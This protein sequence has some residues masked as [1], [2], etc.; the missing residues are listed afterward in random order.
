MASGTERL[1]LTAR[2]SSLPRFAEAGVEA[3]ER[4]WLRALDVNAAD[5][6]EAL[7]EEIEREWGG[8]DVLINNAGVMVRSV[9]EHV[10]EAD[11]LAQMGVNF[12][13]PMELA[14]LCLPSM[15]A[16][17]RGRI[18]NVSSVGGMMAMPTM[19]IYSASKFALEGGCEALWYE[20]RPWNIKVSL[21]EPGFIR[22]DA[23]QKVRL[24]ELSAHSVED[25]HD[26]YHAHYEHMSPFI[27]RVMRY[28]FATHER[29]ARKIERTM[30][31]RSPPLRVSGT[32]DAW[33]FSMMRRVL[34][35]RLY[36]WLLYRS[37]PKVR[38]WGDDT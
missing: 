11:R 1:V 25:M 37:L 16:K 12:R 6:R 3:S 24:T 2:A 29:V 23:Y 4:V 30:R 36:H 13:S 32:F 31:R 15:R 26:P 19:G 17:R 21:I 14:R 7:I 33:M 22:S 28:T 10:R 38:T 34:P 8:V 5:Q 18:I 20:V 27:G 9:V 35:R